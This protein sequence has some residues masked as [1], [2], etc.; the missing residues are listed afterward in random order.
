MSRSGR[1]RRMPRRRL[2]LIGPRQSHN[3]LV[4]KREP[5]WRADLK[6]APTLVQLETASR[7]APRSPVVSKS[8]RLSSNRQTLAY[9]IPRK[10]SSG[11]TRARSQS[12][13]PRSEPTTSIRPS[14]RID[15][16]PYWLGTPRGVGQCTVFEGW[17][18]L[19]RGQFVLILPE[20]FVRRGWKFGAKRTCRSSSASGSAQDLD[21]RAASRLSQPLLASNVPAG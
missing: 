2:C 9:P 19:V 10:P 7:N 18:D 12:T 3:G 15:G 16:F 5:T 17:I 6:N 4:A 14:C 13:T 21:P 8:S 11:V 1:V 20:R